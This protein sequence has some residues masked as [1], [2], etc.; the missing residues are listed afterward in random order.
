MRDMFG[1]VRE[2]TADQN[3]QV[4]QEIKDGKLIGRVVLDL[5]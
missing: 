4:F 2:V 5:Q 3:V 1:S